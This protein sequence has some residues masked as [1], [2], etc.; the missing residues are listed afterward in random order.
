[1]FFN[2]TPQEVQLERLTHCVK[3]EFYNEGT[4]SKCGCFM[5]FKVKNADSQCPID[6]WGKYGKTLNDYLI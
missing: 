2:K 5:M 1:M 4:C 6:K 3:C